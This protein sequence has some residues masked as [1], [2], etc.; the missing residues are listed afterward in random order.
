MG[1][2]RV[3]D[4]GG[5]VVA[6]ELCSL[7]MAIVST[8]QRGE[9]WEEWGEGKAWAST[10]EGASRQG[11]SEA[12]GMAMEVRGHCPAWRTR[13]HMVV[14][15]VGTRVCALDPIFQHLRSIFGPGRKYGSC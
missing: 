3:L 2:A 10:L 13:G 12:G 15:V 9:R 5:M 8:R 4:G 14:Q 1:A 7:A 11:R 6:K